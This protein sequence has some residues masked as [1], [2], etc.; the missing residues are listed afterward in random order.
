MKTSS[1]NELFPYSSFD[2]RLEIKDENRICWFKD[3]YDLK[4]YLNR[5]KLDKRKIKILHRNEEP[6]Q[7]SQTNESEI[8][9]GIGS[10]NH[11]SANT[12][13]KRTKSVDSNSNISRTN[14][15]KK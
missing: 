6:I 2:V 8:Q 15:R 3:S 9:S 1:E 7:P 5:Y 12:T 14:K 11:G 10:T 4:K 13:R